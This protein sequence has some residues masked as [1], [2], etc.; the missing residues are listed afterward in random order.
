[1][2]ALERRSLKSTRKLLPA[3]ALADSSSSSSSDTVNVN[4]SGT[5][6]GGGGAQTND[7]K[8]TKDDEILQDKP[9][10]RF[11]RL[12]SGFVTRT[13]VAFG[14]VGVVVALFLT[15]FIFGR[16]AGTEETYEQ[17]SDF[18]LGSDMP[19]LGEPVEGGLC[20][21]TASGSCNEPVMAPS[22][23]GL[24]GGPCRGF[25]EGT[26]A[27]ALKEREQAERARYYYH[28]CN[29]ETAYG[30]EDRARVFCQWAVEIGRPVGAQSAQDA[31]RRLRHL[32]LT[33]DY[34]NRSA[35]R[36]GRDNAFNPLGGQIR[37]DQ[38]QRA[39]K[40]LAH[41]HGEITGRID[42]ATRRAVQAFQEELLFD[43]T[44]ALTAE[45]TVLLVCSAA[46]IAEDPA[47]QNLLGTMYAVGLGVRQST[48]QALHWFNEASRL[49]S[50]DAAWNLAL[51]YGTRTT[52]SSVIVCDADLSVERADSYL[53]EAYD[54]G[55][56][57]AV[58]VVERY[59]EETP[60]K[61]WQRISGELNKP[62]ALKRV[63]K[64]CNPNG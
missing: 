19:S 60:E 3:V 64:G 49:G 16:D 47:S 61:R 57:G 39:L 5:K 48:D 50:V 54:A 59:G 44:G 15:G 58:R 21:V 53:K 56:P 52:E 41:Y 37:T 27:Q 43:R 30:R 4:I 46:E 13:L 8:P 32:N 33:C 42:G 10:A 34:D 6:T 23:A 36:V 62:E 2:R 29:A 45:Q 22:L 28:R 55:H 35:A 24:E 31:A 7:D 12:V 38:R 26:C 18:P 9:L 51:L 17:L 14:L 40:A 11:L 63:G 25:D 20:N 1:M